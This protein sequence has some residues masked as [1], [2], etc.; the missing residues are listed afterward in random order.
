MPAAFSQSRADC[1]A[2]IAAVVTNT[3]ELAK[4]LD[5]KSPGQPH[6]RKRASREVCARPITSVAV[7]A[8][9]H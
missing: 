7:P 3:A 5:T 8:R 6:R 9:L 4:A 1:E 2:I